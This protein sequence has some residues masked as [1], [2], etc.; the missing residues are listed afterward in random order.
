M[1]HTFALVLMVFGIVGCQ[2]TSYTSHNLNSDLWE[3]TGESGE[4]ILIGKHKTNNTLQSAN[5]CREDAV[6]MVGQIAS[7]GLYTPYQNV[8]ETHKN[9]AVRLLG[10]I[11]KTCQITNQ[12]YFQEL[13][14]YRFEY[15]CKEYY[16]RVDYL[17]KMK[18]I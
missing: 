1:K 2:L 8:A 17:E 10:A 6:K 4:C 12:V 3:L 13:D 7:L 16:S 5:S 15:I 14:A 9:T 18:S 11:G